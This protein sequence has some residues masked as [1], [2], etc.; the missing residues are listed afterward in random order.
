MTDHDEIASLKKRLN[1]IDNHRQRVLHENHRLSLV[2]DEYRKQMAGQF[3]VARDLRDWLAG[4]AMPEFIAINEKVT[5]G[6]EDVTY[7]M[8]LKVTAQ[9]AYA[10][11]D[12]MMS[13]R[14]KGQTSAPASREGSE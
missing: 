5:V 8:A 11:A 12:A 9:Q 2:I 3:V 1:E 13:E 6:R 4:M 7:E 14:L 10:L